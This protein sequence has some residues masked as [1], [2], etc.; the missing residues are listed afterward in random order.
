[1]TVRFFRPDDLSKLEQLHQAQGFEYEFPDL[2]DPLYFI[3]L[4]GEED[5][6]IVNAA[7]AHLTAEIFFLAD[8]KAGDPEQ[9]FANFKTLHEA[10]CEVAYRTGGLS[11][12]HCWIP[13]QIARPFGRRLLKLGWKRPLWTSFAKEL[14]K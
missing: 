6:K 9:R 5:G 1:M 8:N 4:V 10:G 12:L 2:N 14:G 13:P 3:K 11:D 7:V